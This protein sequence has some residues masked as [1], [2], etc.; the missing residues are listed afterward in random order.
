MVTLFTFFAGQEAKK[1]IFAAVIYPKSAKVC[2]SHIAEPVVFML[3]WILRKDA[4]FILMVVMSLFLAQPLYALMHPTGEGANFIIILFIVIP[5]LLSGIVKA[6]ILRYLKSK[7]VKFRVGR[8]ILIF[9]F[10][11]YVLVRHFLSFMTLIFGL[12]YLGF[13][14]YINMSLLIEKG[15]DYPELKKNK[16]M[17]AKALLLSIIVPSVTIIPGGIVLLLELLG[18]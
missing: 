4:V 16:K 18:S 6:I 9:L 12:L 11:F 5:G 2:L 7:D 15:Q 13:F 14:S 1:S 3:Q 10:E 8:F 17:W